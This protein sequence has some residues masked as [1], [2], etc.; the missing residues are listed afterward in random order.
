MRRRKTDSDLWYVDH[1]QPHKA[2]LLSWLKGK[3]P[4]TTDLEDVVQEA[5]FKVLKAHTSGPIINPKAYLFLTARN[6]VLSRIRRHRFEEPPPAQEIDL[7]EILEEIDDPMEQ[8]SRKEEIQILIEAIKSLPKRSRQVLTL[9]KVYG[10]SMRETA[11]KLGISESAVGSHSAI[12][13]E[14]CEAYLRQYRIGE[15]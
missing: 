3:F 11:L 9:R 15:S 5:M 6:L 4:D 10:Y 7:S 2:K 13:I 1:I 14:K 8:V 12:G